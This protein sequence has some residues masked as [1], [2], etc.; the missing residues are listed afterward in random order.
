MIEHVYIHIPFCTGKCHY[1]SFVSGKNIEDKDRY[2]I[3]LQ[4]QIKQ[5]YKGE[6]LK[7]LYFGGGTPS[8]LEVED[9]KQL[10]GL[11][12][13]DKNAEITI[14]VNPETVQ[15]EKFIGFKEIGVNRISLG[16]QTFDDEIL[17]QIGRR[18]NSEKVYSAI[19]IIK[20][21]GFE[22]ISIDLMY[23]LPTQTL[24]GFEKDIEKAIGLNIQHISSY[25]LKIEE[26]SYF[27]KNVPLNIADD[28]MQAQMFT[29]LCEKLK[30]SGF[31]HYEISNF[32]KEG[33]SSNHNNSYWK[34]K[35]YYGFGLNASGYVQNVRYRNED[36]F[37][38]YIKN[39]CNRAEEDE[40]SVQEIMENEIF[41]SLRLKDG[42]DVLNLNKKFNIDFL[43]RYKIVIQK[44]S[45][46]GLI[47]VVK[48]RCM[49]THAGVLLSNE[50]MCEFLE[51][52]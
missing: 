46:L 5:E 27:G 51:I 17:K 48:D 14:E 15:Y 38:K 28:E 10:I 26:D 8:L 20:R 45:E 2:L 22:N 37:E 41:L 34:N 24:Q 19:D 30:Q 3:A 7:T 16:V 36:D 11:F 1:C 40:L 4:E 42:V 39:P 44:Y 50:I 6:K 49:L 21:V 32:A 12:V 35:K 13:L 47:K 25:G 43:E 52:G 33:F 18:H 23:G 29:R 9:V 31:E